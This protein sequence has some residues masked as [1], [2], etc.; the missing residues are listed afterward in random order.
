MQVIET[1]NQGLPACPFIEKWLIN[2]IINAIQHGFLTCKSKT[3]HL[4]ECCHDWNIGLSLNNYFIRTQTT[5][6]K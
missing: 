1:R 2:A 3:T 4:L 5:C 6:H